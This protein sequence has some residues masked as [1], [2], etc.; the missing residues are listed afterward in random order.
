MVRH[1]I[2]QVGREARQFRRKHGVGA[3]LPEDLREAAAQLAASHETQTIIRELEISGETLRRWKER[4]AVTKSAVVPESSVTQRA[5]TKPAT[6][7]PF[8]KIKKIDVVEIKTSGFTSAGRPEG[9][10]SFVEVTRPDGWTVR[11]TGDL[12]KVLA[13]A[14]VGNFTL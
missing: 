13:T 5:A 6:V 10:A 11:M 2:K 7:R 14:M 8:A 3:H 12:A 9:P 1:T 4:Y